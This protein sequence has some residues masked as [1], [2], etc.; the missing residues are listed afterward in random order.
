[1]N[2]LLIKLFV[3]TICAVLAA[4]ALAQQE[5]E[6]LENDN[7]S[8]KQRELEKRL[9]NLERIILDLIEKIDL[10]MNKKI[11]I[12]GKLSRHINVKVLQNTLQQ[13]LSLDL[14][15][16]IP[17]NSIEVIIADPPYIQAKNQKEFV[18]FTEEWL[19]ESFRVLKNTGTLHLYSKHSYLDGY[20]SSAEKYGFHYVDKLVYEDVKSKKVL[21][22]A[23]YQIYVIRFTKDKNTECKINFSTDIISEK[24]S[25]TM[26][27]SPN[28][29]RDLIASSSHKG[30]LVLIPF[31]GTGGE[32]VAC[33]HMQRNWIYAEENKGLLNIAKSRLKEINIS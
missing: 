4:P 1:M 5:K 25:Y 16:V 28:I 11:K 26:G 21:N 13:Q 3:L 30:D 22:N 17:D 10:D 33:T 2:I 24:Q 19:K 14:L 32:L 23:N 7:I 8:S 29:S 18:P 6:S 31:G 15:K 9:R 27:K 12:Y 20:K